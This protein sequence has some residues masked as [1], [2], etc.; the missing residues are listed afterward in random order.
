LPDREPATVA[1]WL[2]ARPSIEIIARDR[3]G[4]YGAAAAQGRPEALQVADRWHLFENASAALLSA[5]RHQMG[6]IRAA[7]GQSP[8]DPSVLTAA[9]RLQHAGWRRRAEADAAVLALH[10]DGVAIKE[11]V[12]RTGRA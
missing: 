2:A 5:V 9:E 6:A 11:I 10:K 1:A 12:R 3:G 8:V 7:L 4:S